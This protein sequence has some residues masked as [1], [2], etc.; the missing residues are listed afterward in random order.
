MAG[1]SFESVSERDG[2]R[3]ETRENETRRLS[4]VYEKRSEICR[5]IELTH[6][7]VI[8]TSKRTGY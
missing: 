7:L 1:E 3:C 5:A 6:T 8:L 2:G 4:H